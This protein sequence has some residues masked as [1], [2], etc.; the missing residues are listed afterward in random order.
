MGATRDPIFV[1]SPQPPNRRRECVKRA[2]CVRTHRHRGTRGGAQAETV[3][4]VMELHPHRSGQGK[5]SSPRDSCY[6]ME[7]GRRTASLERAPGVRRYQHWQ[8]G[9]FRRAWSRAQRWETLQEDRAE[10]GCPRA[11]CMCVASTRSR[12]SCTSLR[13]AHRCKCPRARAL[14]NKCK[15]SP[16]PCARRRCS[17]AKMLSAFAIGT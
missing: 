4:H 3:D 9:W 13:V 8:M 11:C 16:V 17:I 1:Y 14:P 5:E 10:R 7:T 6:G 2:R 12:A 15:K